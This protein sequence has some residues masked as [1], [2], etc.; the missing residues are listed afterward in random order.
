MKMMVLTGKD[1]KEYTDVCSCSTCTKTKM[2]GNSVVFIKTKRMC[3][4]C[5]HASPERFT[6][7][8][9]NNQCSIVDAV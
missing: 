3:H 6:L 7:Y 5:L 2:C 4:D 9:I 1:G 8:K